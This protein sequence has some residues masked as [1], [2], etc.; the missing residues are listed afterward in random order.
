M[1]KLARKAFPVYYL[2]DLDEVEKYLISSKASTSRISFS[3]ILKQKL[4]CIPNDTLLSELTS[5]NVIL[6][7]KNFRK[8]LIALDPL[9]S[10]K[11]GQT[12]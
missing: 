5:H 4:G 11:F 7:F 8:A 12:L 2:L 9:P 1:K 6:E 10:K 3:T